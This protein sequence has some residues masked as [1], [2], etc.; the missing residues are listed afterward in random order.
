MKKLW[1]RLGVIL[2]ITEDEAEAI[3]GTRDDDAVETLQAIIH[4]GRFQVIG[5]S[6]IPSQSIEEYNST[7]GTTYGVYETGFDMVQPIGNTK[8]GE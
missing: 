8:V 2:E 7:Y 4:A 1:M 5:D 3:L 6:Y